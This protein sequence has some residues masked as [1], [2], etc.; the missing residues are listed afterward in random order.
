MLEVILRLEVTIPILTSTKFGLCSLH[1]SSC[2]DERKYA[3]C[4]SMLPWGKHQACLK[5]RNR[6]IGKDKCVNAEKDSECSIC[7][8]LKSITQKEVS[9]E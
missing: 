2:A 4:S 3:V 9:K 5:C 8:G 6:N 7:A 1:F